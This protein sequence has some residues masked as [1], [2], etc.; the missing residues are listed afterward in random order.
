VGLRG[1][2]SKFAN[3]ME[4]G[5]LY[6][7][8]E[9][10]WY[11]A[12][13]RNRSARFNSLDRAGDHPGSG[14]WL[15]GGDQT[16]RTFRSGSGLASGYLHGDRGG[17]GESYE[18][19]EERGESYEGAGERGESYEGTE[20]TGAPHE[21]TG[22]GDTGAPHEGTGDGDTEATG[23]TGADRSSMKRTQKSLNGMRGSS[24]H[25]FRC[26]NGC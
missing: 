9:R 7:E 2:S 25:T 18:G 1:E 4:V 8:G 5:C 21:G 23:D 13:S 12:A 11:S 24:E 10:D 17:E 19:A 15:H 14:P 26:G 6:G 22:D 16:M 3:P 20:D